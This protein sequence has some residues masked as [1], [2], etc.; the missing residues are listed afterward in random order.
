M[1]NKPKSHPNGMDKSIRCPGDIKVGETA[2]IREGIGP[3][4]KWRLGR[5][6][7]FRLSNNGYGKAVELMTECGTITRPIGNLVILPT[8]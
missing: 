5:I 8:N 3:T 1:P 7:Y 4:T 6:R 2:A